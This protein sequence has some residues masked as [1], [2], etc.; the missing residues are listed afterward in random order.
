MG[1]QTALGPDN[2]S[3]KELANREEKHRK[4]L[5]RVARGSGGAGVVPTH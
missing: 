4:S 2:T 5:G 3:K 1:P